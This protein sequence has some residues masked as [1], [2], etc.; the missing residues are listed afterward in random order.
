MESGNDVLGQAGGTDAGKSLRTCI[1]DA[2]L[3]KHRG[4]HEKRK[5]AEAV[6]P[7]MRLC[8]ARRLQHDASGWMTAAAAAKQTNL[9]AARRCQQKTFLNRISVIMRWEVMFC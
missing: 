1:A 8:I 7:V 3:Q 4:V 6:P 2:A 9:A 5:G